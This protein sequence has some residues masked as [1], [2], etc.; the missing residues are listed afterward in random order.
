[1]TEHIMEILRKVNQ[2]GTAVIMCT[3]EHSLLARYP[4]RVIE[5]KNGG[6]IDHAPPMED[7][8]ADEPAPPH[9]SVPSPAELEAQAADAK[10]D[11]PAE[12][13]KVPTA[14]RA[15][16]MA[17]PSPKAEPELVSVAAAPQT[18]AYRPPMPRPLT[19]A[20]APVI[21]H[22][23]ASLRETA[24]PPRKSTGPTSPAEA[25]KRTIIFM[26]EDEALDQVENQPRS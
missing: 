13:P 19:E 24:P 26:D 3:H 9:E 25:I 6:I 1:V 10:A 23:G 7:E 17:A 15:E 2:Q 14:V 16:S 22:S 5:V 8:L 4:A 20:P 21:V 11:A 18:A 12:A